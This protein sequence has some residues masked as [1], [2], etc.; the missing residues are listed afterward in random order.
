V[1]VYAKGQELKGSPFL[2]N[3]H[4]SGF[5]LPSL[6]SDAEFCAFIASTTSFVVLDCD[7]RKSPEWP[8][9]AAFNDARDIANYVLSQYAP[10]ALALSGF[11]AGGNLAMSLAVSLDIDVVNALLVFYGNPDLE[12]THPPPSNSHISGLQLPTWL[13]QFFY[14]CLVL[15]TQDRADPRLSPMNAELI[16][17]PKEVFLACGEA[18]NLH[19][20]GELLADKLR[21]RKQGQVEWMSIENEAHA[22][23]KHP[24]AASKARVER[25][26]K[27][28]RDTLERSL[29]VER[30]GK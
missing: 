26:Y 17:W 5:V 28:A 30:S 19:R 8:F 12:A 13:R 11:S 6:G 15:Q 23:D 9:P 14:R 20:A 29:D 27:A 3:F 7:Y 21:S 25:M 1:D 22:F 2:L 24:K 18:D 10:S 16:R 4:G